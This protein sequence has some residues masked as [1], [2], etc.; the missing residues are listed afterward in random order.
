[1]RKRFDSAISSCIE[2]EQWDVVRNRLQNDTE[3]KRSYKIYKSKMSALHLA[4]QHNPPADIIKMLL[5]ANPMAAS[6]R[7]HP[8][9]E[10]PLHFATGQNM[11]SEEVILLL[12]DANKSAI[13]AQTTQGISPLHQACTF[14][15]SFEILK[16]LVNKNPEAVFIRDCHDR[17]PFD[18]A[19]V[20]YSIFY[21]DTWKIWYLLSGGRT[22]RIKGQPYIFPAK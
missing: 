5:D 13:S 22:K 2:F 18:V 15:A 20:M 12:A 16:I 21:P 3:R 10:L 14:K 1:M 17:T 19:K 7:S 11:A 9:G 4:C 8:F 6:A